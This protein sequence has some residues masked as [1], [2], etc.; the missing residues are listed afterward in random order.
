MEQSTKNNTTISISS[1][2]IKNC[3]DVAKYMKKCGIPCFVA[4][5]YTIIKNEEDYQIENGCQIKI[6]SHKPSVVNIDLWKGL[7]ESFGLTCAHIDVEGKFRGC[8]YNYFRDSKCPG[9]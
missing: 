7:K 1:T 5:N 2:K 4:G 3:Y 6:G 9:R 8:I